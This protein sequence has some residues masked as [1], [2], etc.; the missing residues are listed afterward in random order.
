LD[1]YLELADIYERPDATGLDKRRLLVLYDSYVDL[2]TR[3]RQTPPALSRVKERLKQLKDGRERIS[4]VVLPSIPEHNP[5]VLHKF[6]CFYRSAQD[7]VFAYG[8]LMR[9]ELLLVRVGEMDPDTGTTAASF[10]GKSKGS[11]FFR[12]I[13]GQN[14]PQQVQK[15]LDRLDNVSPVSL[16]GME[17]EFRQIPLNK[18]HKIEYILDPTTET[19]TVR[20][21]L[22]Q[23]GSLELLFGAP[24]Q[25]DA[26]KVTL[27]LKR[28][29][30]K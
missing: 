7:V 2:A 23:E 29:T 10:G 25:F 21:Q 13:K 11:G 22:Y 24:A 20:I 4:S 9:N 15:N 16:D 30:N 3:S 28:L 19:R 14:S 8:M 18:I 5:E 12:F 17:N 27:I 26:D 1:A 6:R